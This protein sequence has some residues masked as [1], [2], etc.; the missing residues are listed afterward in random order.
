MCDKCHVIFTQNTSCFRSHFSKELPV[1]MC[2]VFFLQLVLENEVH[3][4][5]L[6]NFFFSGFTCFG[7]MTYWE[8]LR[9][10]SSGSP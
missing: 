5:N 8:F 9:V 4:L 3:V 1:L 7:M 6:V 2:C 10:D